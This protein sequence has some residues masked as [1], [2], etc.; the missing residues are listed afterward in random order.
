MRLTVRFG[1]DQFEVVAGLDPKK[2]AVPFGAR[3]TKAEIAL[4]LHPEFK[5]SGQVEFQIAP[6]G[7]RILDGSMTFTSDASGLVATG[8]INGHL[9]GVDKA[10]GT[11]EYRAQQWSGKITVE[12][13]QI[14]IPSPEGRSR[15]RDHRQH[16]TGRFR[17]RSPRAARWQRGRLRVSSKDRGDGF[18]YTGKGEFMCPASTRSP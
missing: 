3:V 1:P 2:L 18:I 13:S 8:T 11:I 9:P 15:C 7:R 12:S 17:A 16:R 10:E 4:L 5:P 14:K 6:G